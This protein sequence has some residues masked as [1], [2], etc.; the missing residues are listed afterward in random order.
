MPNLH[1]LPVDLTKFGRTNKHEIFVPIDEPHGDIEATV[2][3]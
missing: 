1:C 2:S 3:R